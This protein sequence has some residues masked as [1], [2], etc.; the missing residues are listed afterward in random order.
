MNTPLHRT[1]SAAAAVVLLACGWA[2]SAA[3]QEAVYKWVDENG[4]IHYGQSLPPGYKDLAHEKLNQSG[5]VIGR[6][7]RALTAAEREALAAQEAIVRQ[8][9]MEHENQEKKDRLLLAAYRSE[10][11]IMNA[12]NGE[13]NVLNEQYTL[14]TNSIQEQRKS[15]R[16]LAAQAAVLERAGQPVPEHL[17]AP[18]AALRT[19]IARLRGQIERLEEQIAFSRA[20]YENDL[21]RYRS[22][23]AEAAAAAPGG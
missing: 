20:T 11:D 21:A 9:A 7:G 2:F 3:A 6:T 4:E 16:E 19:V 14:V 10:A 1:F 5:T 17:V 13:L 18:L 15:L 22:L 12:M 8:A 23:A